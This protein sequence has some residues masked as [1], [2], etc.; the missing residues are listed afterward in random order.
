MT[1]CSHAPTVRFVIP[2][3]TI[4]VPGVG[5]TRPRVAPQELA[6][7][8]QDVLAAR[9]GITCERH[10]GDGTAM[11]I[12]STR[13]IAWFYPAFVQ[14]QTRHDHPRLSGHPLMARASVHDGADTIAKRLAERYRQLHPGQA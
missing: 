2:T 12:L 4:H 5:G 1:G 14:W 7:R 9:H 6:E 8:V 11:L 10:A 13:L 3:Q